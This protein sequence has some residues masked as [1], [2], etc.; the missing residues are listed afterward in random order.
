MPRQV[1]GDHAPTRCQES[2]HESVKLSD[3]SAPPVYEQHGRTAVTP[4]VDSDSVASGREI[5]D[6]SES[7]KP[8]LSSRWDP[9]LGDPSE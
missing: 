8:G 9:A 1:E 4:L 3:S 2:I 5:G 6:P 7:A